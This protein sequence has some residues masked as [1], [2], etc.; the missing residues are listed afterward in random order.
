MGSYLFPSAISIPDGGVATADLADDAVTEAKLDSTLQLARAQLAMDEVASVPTASA[1]AGFV[2]GS[3]TELAVTQLA[4][5]V[6]A[7][8][9]QVAGTAYNHLGARVAGATSTSIAVTT[10]DATNARVDVVVLTAAGAY[11]V[12]AGTPAGS[13]VDPTLT[14]GDVP[15]ARLAIA[16]MQA[17]VQTANITDLR[18]RGGLDGEK[19]I[20]DSV[21]ALAIGA[22]FAGKA[23][24]TKAAN[25]VQTSLLAALTGQAR[26]VIIHVLVDEV[27]A[28]GDGAQPT[29]SIG[30]TSAATKFAATSRFT[31]A[32]AATLFTFGGELTAGTAL[33]VTAVAGTGTTET[34]GITVTVIALP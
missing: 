12:R 4:S 10:A 7:V 32:A 22:G 29:F 28:N 5:P 14:A 18:E 33:F 31:D 15:L 19:I 13:P 9:V 1:G 34:G 24:Y 16:A 17:D 25:G 3:S 6:M 30:E 21:S 2:A 23:S 20:D 26:K 8:R 27:F 11:A